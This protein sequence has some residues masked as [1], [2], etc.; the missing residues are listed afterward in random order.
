MIDKLK[1]CPGKIPFDDMTKMFNHV[2][3]NALQNVDGELAFKQNMATIDFD[4][5]RND[6]VSS[7]LMDLVGEDMKTFRAA[8]KSKVPQNFQDLEKLMAL[9]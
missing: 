3:E 2:W 1:E 4:G 6:L 5:I 8:K 7:K 9:L